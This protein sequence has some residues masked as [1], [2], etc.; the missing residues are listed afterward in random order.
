MEVLLVGISRVLWPF[1]KDSAVVWFNCPV[2][3]EGLCFHDG[4]C[5]GFP[6]SH[7]EAL[8]FGPIILWFE[9]CPV[10]IN[11]CYILVGILVIFFVCLLS[12][13]FLVGKLLALSA[14]LKR[15]WKRGFP[16]MGQAY[17]GRATCDWDE[18]NEDSIYGK[19][20]KDKILF[21]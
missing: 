8:S 3:R 13:S 15:D 7:F 6:G 2:S 12:L 5:L 21:G 1:W 14:V 20:K 18:D 17:K 19:P 16:L 11:Y 10:L 4:R 9:I